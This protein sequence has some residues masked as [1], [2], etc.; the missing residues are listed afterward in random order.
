MPLLVDAPQVPQVA[1]VEPIQV[2]LQE[3]GLRAVD[4]REQGPQFPAD[5]NPPA[6]PNNSNS[7]LILFIGM[8][9]TR[10]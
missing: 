5:S 1:A 4:E 7:S 6:L 10:S 9:S 2:S 3:T 8:S